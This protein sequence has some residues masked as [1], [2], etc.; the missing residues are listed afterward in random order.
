MWADMTIKGEQ[1][2]PWAFGDPCKVK[3]QIF[4]EFFFLISFTKIF[5]VI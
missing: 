1:C 4:N 2:D 5:I 3:A